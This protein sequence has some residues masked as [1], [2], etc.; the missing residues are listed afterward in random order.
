MIF[1]S[2]NLPLN[3]QN[4]VENSNELSTQVLQDLEQH[5]PPLYGEHQF[6]QL[7][8]NVDPNGFVTPAGGASGINTPYG[9]HSRDASMEDLVTMSAV[10]NGEI[11]AHVLHNRLYNIQDHGPSRYARDRN[12]TTVP[13]PLP[14]DGTDEESS[15]RQNSVPQVESLPTSAGS[16][17]HQ[18]YGNTQSPRTSDDDPTHSGSR[19]PRAYAQHIEIDEVNEIYRLPSYGRAVRTP[20]RTPA[21]E[22]PPTYQAAVSSSI[23]PPLSLLPPGQAPPAGAS[24][25]FRDSRTSAWTRGSHASH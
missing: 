7:Y 14:H 22:G 3:D 19:T 25:Y 11:S 5:A 10:A 20:V 9:F 6:D 4:Q 23:G 21:N 13:G 18:S 16:S 1:I 15:G 12:A 24:S 8:S 2:P 17:S